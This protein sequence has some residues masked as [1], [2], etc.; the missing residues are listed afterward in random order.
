MFVHGSSIR[1]M[2]GGGTSASEGGCLKQQ[3]N[4][5]HYQVGPGRARSSISRA[6]TAMSRASTGAFAVPAP[7][8]SSFTGITS[9]AS[10]G[11]GARWP[12]NNAAL[13]PGPRPFYPSNIAADR[14]VRADTCGQRRDAW[15]ETR[16]ILVTAR[17]LWGSICWTLAFAGRRRER[18][19]GPPGNRAAEEGEKLGT[20]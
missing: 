17:A 14:N 5:L 4:E 16:Q 3:E 19:W 9:A 20:C 13:R 6:V 12:R 18:V 15:G 2:V 7:P 1:P 8:T 11:A 10:P